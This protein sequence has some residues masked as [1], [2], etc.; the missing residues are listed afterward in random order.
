MFG[1][2]NSIVPVIIMYY[3]YHGLKQTGIEEVIIKAF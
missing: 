3:E 2:I 1:L